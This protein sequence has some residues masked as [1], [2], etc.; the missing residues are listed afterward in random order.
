[1]RAPPAGNLPDDL[2]IRLLN[3][4]LDLARVV[5]TPASR[6]EGQ[7]ALVACAMIGDDLQVILGKSSSGLNISLTISP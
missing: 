6:F 4:T 7:R 3:L 2:A 5:G 1:M